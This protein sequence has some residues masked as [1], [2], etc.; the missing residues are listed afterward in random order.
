MELC[1]LAKE[2]LEEAISNMEDADY[3]GQARVYIGNQMVLVEEEDFNELKENLLLFDPE[4]DDD[5][6]NLEF[7]DIV[8]PKC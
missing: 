1:W 3:E 5:I 8:K 7:S 2:I 6:K 4:C